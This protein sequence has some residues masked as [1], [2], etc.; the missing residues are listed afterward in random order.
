MPTDAAEFC[1]ES[2]TSAFTRN[3]PH[4]LIR[5]TR[6]SLATPVTKRVSPSSADQTYA[7]G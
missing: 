3:L 6:L 2:T 4:H 5:T 7:C 1:A